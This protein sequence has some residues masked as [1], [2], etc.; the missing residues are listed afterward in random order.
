[1]PY[2]LSIIIV[3][4][5]GG[6]L[7]TRCVETIIG[8]APA[9]T[10]EIVVVDNASDDDSLARLRS[11]RAAAPLIAQQRLRIVDNAENRGF[12][13]ANNQ[14]FAVTGSPCVLLL[15]PDTEV[16][17]GAIDT[18]MQRLRSDHRIG[19]CGPRMLNADGSLQVSVFFNPPRVWHTVLSQ[20][21]LYRLLPKRIR[22]ELLLGR[23]WAH[24]RERF[25][26]MLGGAAL[27]ARRAMID[28]VGGFDERFPMYAEDNEWCWRITKSR[29]RLL[30]VPAAVV[31]HRGA[32]SARRRWSARDQLRVKVRAGFDFERKVLPRWRLTAN[33]LANYVVVFVQIAARRIVGIHRP[34][35][36]LIKELHGENLRRS[37]N[38]H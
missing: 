7:L 25:V 23:H 27:L 26:P 20:L 13:P 30:F 35:L 22:G 38:G 29:W 37:L 10:Y 6:V 36:A 9:V 21:W 34:D 1:M 32:Q 24:D 11:S 12:G 5:N 28:E 19:A 3:N 31:L 16:S 18:L 14:G 4:W 8:S 2:D 33:Q 17:P 15:N